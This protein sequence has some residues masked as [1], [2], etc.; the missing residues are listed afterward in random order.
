MVLVGRRAWEGKGREKVWIERENLWRKNP[1]QK[2]DLV[3]P[4]KKQPSPP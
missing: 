2:S 4:L 1:N 3:R